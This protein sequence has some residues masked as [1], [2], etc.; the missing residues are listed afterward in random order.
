MNAGCYKKIWI[1]GLKKHI[2]IITYVVGVILENHGKFDS[3][4][5]LDGLG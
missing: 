3:L 4:L 5:N 2:I 1:M